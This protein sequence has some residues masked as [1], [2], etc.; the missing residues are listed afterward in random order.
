VKPLTAVLLNVGLLF[1]CTI[2]YL[3]FPELVID[4][5]KGQ[6]FGLAFYFLLFMPLALFLLKGCLFQNLFIIAFCQCATQFVLGL[7][8]WLEFRFG[9]LISPVISYEMSFLSK[10]ILIPVFLF[11]GVKMLKRFFAAWD[12]SQYEPV[13]FNIFD[14]NTNLKNRSDTDMHTQ[15]FW[16]VLWLIPATFCALTA[17]SGTV[18]TLTEATRLPFALSRIFSIT[19]LLTCIALMTDIMTRERE[20]ADARFREAVIMKLRKSSEKSHAETLSALETM[21]SDREAMIITVNKIIDYA[22]ESNHEQIYGILK[23]RMTVLD[24]QYN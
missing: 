23:D 7:G 4:S 21:K 22:E 14:E 12:E 1:L 18:L 13:E 20:T 6:I 3:C 15:P 5:G 9:D 16:K 10:L 17:I 11:L 8:N 24:S 2:Y 19:G